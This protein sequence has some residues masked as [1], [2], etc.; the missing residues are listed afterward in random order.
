[1]PQLVNMEIST[2]EELY[3]LGMLISNWKGETM[4]IEEEGTIIAPLLVAL[5]LY[6][7]IFAFLVTTD[8]DS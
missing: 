4:P 1:M 8:E 7:P 5:S 6:Y 2:Q 3:S